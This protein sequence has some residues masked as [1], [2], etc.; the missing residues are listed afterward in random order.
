MTTVEL[1][2][3]SLGEGPPLVILH[4]LYGAGTNWNSHAK[5]LSERFRV[6]LV[7]LRNHG[8]SPHHPDMSYPAQA[9]DVLALLDRLDIDQALLLGHSM[10]GKAAMVLALQHPQRVRALIAADIAPVSYRDRDHGHARII[11]AL[12]RL[13]LDR[14][15]SREEADRLLSADI[16]AASVRQFLLTNLQ[17]QGGG[18][19]WR[20]PL[21]ILADQLPLIQDFP[22]LE[23][24]FPGPAL[25]IHGA[26]SDYLTEA[27]IPAVRARFPAAHIVAVAGAGHW[28][29]VERPAEFSAQLRAFLEQFHHLDRDAP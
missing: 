19:V 3:T 18:Y 9:A 27:E 6:I 28:L 14:V 12:R 22:P 4:G 5:W 26:E 17:R 1:H 29:H 7:D 25:F 13:P 24:R 11:D 10:G 8:R 2:Y 20:I 23:G 16:A 21:D 15:G